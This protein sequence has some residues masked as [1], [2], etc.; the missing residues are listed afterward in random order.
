ME[1]GEDGE[2]S[3]HNINLLSLLLN[4]I[5]NAVGGRLSRKFYID[6]D[7]HLTFNMIMVTFSASIHIVPGLKCSLC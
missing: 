2:V 5:Y 6:N 4:V 7:W 1:D 3:L